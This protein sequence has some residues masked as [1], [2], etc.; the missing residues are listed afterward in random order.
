MVQ[1]AKGYKYAPMNDM[2]IVAGQILKRRTVIMSI[3][4]KKIN[5]ENDVGYFYEAVSEKLVSD[6]LGEYVTYG[7]RC[8]QNSVEMAFVSD[9]SVDEKEVKS[10]VAHFNSDQLDPLHLYDVLEDHF[11]K[12]S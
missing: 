3:T 7:I 10:L 11:G 9:V 5:E 4:I 8:S 12:E 6:E 2:P 1:N